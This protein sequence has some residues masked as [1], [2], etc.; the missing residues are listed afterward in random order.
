MR[1]VWVPAMQVV[2]AVLMVV[3]A[4]AAAQSPAERPQALL[5]Q[6]IEFLKANQPE[7]AL[8]LLQQAVALD[9]KNPD[10]QALLGEALLDT[11][12]PDQALPHLEQAARLRPTDSPTIF[13]LGVAQLES[14]RAPQAFETLSRLAARDPTEL[15]TKS[16]LAR[17]ALRLKKTE[18]ARANLT[19][20]R[21]LAP[22]KFFCMHSWWSGASR[23]KA[24]QLRASKSSLR[25]TG[26]CRPAGSARSLSFGDPV[27]PGA[28]LPR[29]AV[30]EFARAIALDETQEE[31]ISALVKQQASQGNAAVDRALLERGLDKIPETR[32]AWSRPARC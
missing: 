27:W 8:P 28:A 22:V 21:Q 4:P 31:Y 6:S 23:R 25:S 10:A 17:A 16:Y 20:L 7:R 15:A 2:A 12:H 11:G 32:K 1:T 13:N 19:A 26:N 3:M 18:T 5:Q 30:A 29:D 14:G 24:G 9:P